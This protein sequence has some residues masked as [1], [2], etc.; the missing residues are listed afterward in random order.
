MAIFCVYVSV[1]CC[2]VFVLLLLHYHRSQHNYNRLQSTVTRP[3]VC[4]LPNISG[5]RQISQSAFW[6]PF[7]SCSN[8]HHND[9]YVPLPKSTALVCSTKE[10]QYERVTSRSAELEL[11][12][13]DRNDAYLSGDQNTSASSTLSEYFRSVM[14]MMMMMMMARIM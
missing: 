4:R 3:P 7:L 11:Q 2:T 14:T 13:A 6:S 10:E 12:R 5:W 1:C 9:W 8:L